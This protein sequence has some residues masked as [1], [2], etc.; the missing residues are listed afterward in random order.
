MHLLSPQRVVMSGQS[1]APQCV[2]ATAP[3]PNDRHNLLFDT[4]RHGDLGT[5]N[6]DVGAPVDDTLRSALRTGDSGQQLQ[7]LFT[8]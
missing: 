4:R 5:S 3:L 1:Q 6:S 7:L 2:A 8:W